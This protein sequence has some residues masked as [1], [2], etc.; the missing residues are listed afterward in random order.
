MTRY[1]CLRASPWT[2]RATMSNASLVLAVEHGLGFAVPRIAKL[3]TVRNMPATT[4]FLRSGWCAY[5]QWRV[6]FTSSLWLI[7]LVY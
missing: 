4:Q 3:A 5:S 2:T 7:V 1:S 6:K